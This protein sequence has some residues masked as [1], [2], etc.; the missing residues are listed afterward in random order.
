[1]HVGSKGHVTRATV[2]SI[3]GRQ[4]LMGETYAKGVSCGTYRY[5]RSGCSTFA[6]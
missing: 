3:V 2:G 5:T 1:M 6:G 4:V